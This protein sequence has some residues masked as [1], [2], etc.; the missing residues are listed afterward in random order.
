M[1]PALFVIL[2]FAVAFVGLLIYSGSR[3]GRHETQSQSA[4]TSERIERLEDRVRALEGRVSALVREPEGEMTAAPRHPAASTLNPEIHVDRIPP[5]PREVPSSEPAVSEG[6]WVGMEARIAGWWL[7]RVGIVAI[8][9]AVAFFLKLAFDNEWIG[10]TGRVVIG[11]LSGALLLAWSDWLLKRRYPYFSE[12]IAGL[13]AGVLYLSLY[14]AWDYYHLLSQATI[15]VGMIVVTAGMSLI[16][17]GRNSSRIGLVALA[18]GFATPLLVN[19]GTDQQLTLFSYLL[20]LNGGMILISGKR[21]WKAIEWLAFAATLT[22]YIGWC[23]HFYDATK[24]VPTAIWATLFFA[25]FESLPV[26]RSKRLGTMPPRQAVLVLVN[27]TWYL[28]ALQRLLDPDH[29][30]ALTFAVLGL[31]AAHLMLL[32]LLPETAGSVEHPSLARVLFAGLALTF[33]TLAI[34][35]RLEGRW[36]T[37]A[38]G[39]EGAVLVRAGFTERLR[40]LRGTGMLLIATAAARLLLF[41][42]PATNLIFNARF[43]ACLVFVA[44]GCS[45]IYFAW[46]YAVALGEREKDFFIALGVMTNALLLWALSLE[47]WQA[48]GRQ[49]FFNT[50]D[51]KLSQQLGLSL[52]WIAYA[53]VLTVIGFVVSQQELRWQA[54]ALFGVAIGKVFLYDLGSLDRLYRIVSFVVLGVAL[55]TVSFFYQRRLTARR[56]HSAP[57]EENV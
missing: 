52:L 16:A 44:C 2:L 9:L 12:G 54:L 38:W 56:G 23:I 42:I 7:H 10:P 40:G 1:I 8:L 21:D 20:L 5:M 47:V 24:L 41:P 34:P 28:I 17:L 55:L 25:E 39:V 3:R 31:S 50:A 11:I 18:G 6:N 51:V 43:A 15:F 14:A 22:Y 30:W 13:G 27:S 19:S 37:M 33:V 36:I 26:L 46:A 4:S 32:R 53:G 48:L 35:I 45:A 29:R 49:T 57:S